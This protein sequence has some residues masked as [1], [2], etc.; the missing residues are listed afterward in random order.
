[1]MRFAWGSILVA[2]FIRFTVLKI[3]GAEAVREKLF[4]FFIGVFLGSLGAQLIFF[5]VNLW[6]FLYRPG[7]PGIPEIY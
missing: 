6:L 7:I 1:M 5:L 2:W 4:P 3:G